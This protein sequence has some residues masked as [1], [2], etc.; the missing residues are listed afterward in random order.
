MVFVIKIN[1]ASVKNNLH[2]IA[3]KLVINQELRQRIDSWYGSLQS[4]AIAS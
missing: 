1:A 2:A 3:Q 4:K